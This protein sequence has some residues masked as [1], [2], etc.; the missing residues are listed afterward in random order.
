MFRRLFIALYS[1]LI[2]SPYYVLGFI[3]GFPLSLVL[4]PLIAGFSW[5]ITGNDNIKVMF[6][7]FEKFDTLIHKPL[8]MNELHDTYYNFYNEVTI[9]TKCGKE[10]RK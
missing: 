10:M 1:L 3:I 2:L 5:I 7:A 6:E 9:C 4:V 8:C